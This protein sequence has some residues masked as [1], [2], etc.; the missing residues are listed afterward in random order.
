[1][2]HGGQVLQRIFVNESGNDLG[3]AEDF[4]KFLEL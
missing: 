4:H 3:L 1:M 2:G